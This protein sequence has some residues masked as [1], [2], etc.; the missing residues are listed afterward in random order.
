[1]RS[2]KI[3]E[4]VR[5]HGHLGPWLIMGILAGEF[6]LKR[7]KAEKYFGLDVKVSGAND[8]PRSCIIDGLQ[9]SSGAT[10]GKGNIKKLSNHSKIEIIFVN[11]KNNKKLILIPKEKIVKEL[12]RITSHRESEEIAKNLYKKDCLQ[13]FDL[14]YHNL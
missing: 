4:A 8:K 14:I 10:Y 9:L 5:F 2:I 7:L 6:A 3:E 1:M 12:D 13:I 11:K